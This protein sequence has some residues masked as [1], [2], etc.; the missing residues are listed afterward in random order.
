MAAEQQVRACDELSMAA[1]RFQLMPSENE[2]SVSESAYA[3][4]FLISRGEVSPIVRGLVHCF[5]S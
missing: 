4:P 1:N 3:D 5:V 2:L